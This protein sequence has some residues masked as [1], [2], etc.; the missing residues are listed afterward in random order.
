MVETGSHGG[1]WV[2]VFRMWNKEV[3]YIYSS[4]QWRVADARQY[5]KRNLIRNRAIRKTGRDFPKKKKARRLALHRKITKAYYPPRAIPDAF[6]SPCCLP[7][8]VASDIV[9]LFSEHNCQFRPGV[10]CG[11]VL[12]DD[13]FFLHLVLPFH[14]Y[15]LN[16]VSLHQKKR[17]LWRGTPKKKEVKTKSKIR[18]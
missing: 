4:R 7:R 18:T 17:F 16:N 9:Q 13:F 10:L 3:W 2:L 14:I 5:S 1:R 11:S 8:V 12:V 6:G 15:N